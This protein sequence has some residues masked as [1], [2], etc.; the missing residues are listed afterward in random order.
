LAESGNTELSDY[1]ATNLFTIPTTT[2]VLPEQRTYNE[3]EQ[4]SLFNKTTAEAKNSDLRFTKDSEIFKSKKDWD[5]YIALAWKKYLKID[6]T[7]NNYRNILMS[8]GLGD[9]AYI[10]WTIDGKKGY[11][12]QNFVQSVKMHGNN[13]ILN[14]MGRKFNPDKPDE[15]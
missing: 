6:S 1:I 7:K 8:L 2:A 9:I 3:G 12:A 4:M 5:R 15:P 14:V 10:A 11:A 13:V